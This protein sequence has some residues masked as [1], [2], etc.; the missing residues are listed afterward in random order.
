MDLLTLVVVVLVAGVIVYV[1]HKAPWINP[2]YKMIA[3]GLILLTIVLL[4]L[5]AFGI[6]D[7]LRGVRIPKVK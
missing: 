3:S 7:A 6:I 1:I 2:T 4:V 5:N